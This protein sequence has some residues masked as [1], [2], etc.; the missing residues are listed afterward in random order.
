M[1]DSVDLAI[2]DR[3]AIQALFAEMFRMQTI[4]IIPAANII[5]RR[6]PKRFPT[7]AGIK[8]FT[9]PEAT[10]LIVRAFNLE[11]NSMEIIVVICG[12]ITFAE[13]VLTHGLPQMRKLI[14]KLPTADYQFDRTAKV[15]K[16]TPNAQ[17]A[18]EVQARAGRGPLVQVTFRDPIEAQL[19]SYNLE[20]SR[21]KNIFMGFSGANSRN[22]FAAAC[23]EVTFWVA[24]E[25]WRGVLR[26]MGVE[27]RGEFEGRMKGEGTMMQW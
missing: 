6:A 1:P 8:T 9:C 25:E 27:A 3:D 19:K 16:S 15:T 7:R 2:L 21:E 5:G 26:I 14:L 12:I 20:R 10:I 23:A 17:T 4:A 11:S 13:H 18:M 24:E 22:L